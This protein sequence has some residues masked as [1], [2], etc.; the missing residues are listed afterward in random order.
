M[1]N[2]HAYDKVIDDEQET[3]Q[4][5]NSFTDE[6]LKIYLRR[7]G[8]I[9]ILSREEEYDL[10]M[11]YSKSGDQEARGRLI[12]HNLRLVVSIAK[13]YRNRGMS[14]NDLIKEG[15]VGLIT[16]VEKFD[17]GR[18][19][20]L[21]TPATW[22]IRQA[23][24]RAL[25]NKLRLV[26]V[27]EEW[28]AAYTRI[29]RTEYNLREVLGREPMDEEIALQMEVAVDWLKRA[30]RYMET[31]IVS[32][33]GTPKGND[34]GDLL[35][36]APDDRLNA[37]ELALEQGAGIATIC[38]RSLEPRQRYVLL[39]R[40][41]MMDEL[42]EGDIAEVVGIEQG[43]IKRI[44]NVIAEKMQPPPEVLY[45]RRASQDWV[46]R[47]KLNILEPQEA[48]VFGC[49]FG[50][51]HDHPVSLDDIGKTLGVSHE[52]IRKIEEKA[53]ATLKKRVIAMQWEE[54]RML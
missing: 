14:F 10:A 27:S 5:K 50:R 12:E 6:T 41:G 39:L 19:N 35:C 51:W 3:K 47:V 22:W 28:I 1:A 15:N 8:K 49:R 29:L 45:N 48:F 44:E 13:R 21:S 33:N 18:G 38:L 17:P 26:R 9:D 31:P 40:L 20:R 52:T 36:L 37:E 23:V 43:D 53:M 4:E 11:R 30:R 7:I 46:A 42:T 16:A 54:S 32:L 25:A 2:E 24:E 34:E